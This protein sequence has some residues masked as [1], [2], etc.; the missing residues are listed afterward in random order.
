LSFFS[1]AAAPLTST[2]LAMQAADNSALMTVGEQAPDAVAQLGSPLQVL[3]Y[4]V[5]LQCTVLHLH[6]LAATC[7]MATYRCTLAAVDIG[8]A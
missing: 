3:D 4:W 2:A 6:A 5:H 1:T 7:R 8:D